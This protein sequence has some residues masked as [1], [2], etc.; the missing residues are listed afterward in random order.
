VDFGSRHP[1]LQSG[2]D[3]N[4]TVLHLGRKATAIFL[5]FDGKTFVIAQ[6]VDSFC[7]QGRHHFLRE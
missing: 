1:G 2:V 3:Q 7:S 4:E 6:I 5:T